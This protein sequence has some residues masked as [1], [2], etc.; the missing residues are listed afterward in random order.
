MARVLDKT[1]RAE[2]NRLLKS[3]GQA[4][5]KSF[6]D[7][8]IAQGGGAAGAGN[9]Q[10]GVMQ[11]KVSTMLNN[12]QKAAAAGKNKKAAQIGQKIQNQIQKNP[13]SA[14]PLAERYA[15]DEFNKNL[16]ANRPNQETIGGSRQYITNPDGSITAVDSLDQGQQAL[17][18]QDLAGRQTANEMFL[19]GLQGS[20][21][22]QAYDMSGLPQSPLSQDLASER[23]RIEGEVFDR[24]AGL[25]NR[26]ADRER[27][28]L[29]QQLY[30]RGNVP[31]TPAYDAAMRQFNEG[32]ESQLSQAR[33]NAVAVGGQE[34][35]RNFNIG[36]QGRQNALSE[37]V[38]GR[39]QPMSELQALQGF[40]GGPTM[41]P[42]FFGF[43]PIQYGGPQL[44]Q[45]LGFGLEAELGRGQLDVSRI[46]ANRSGGGGG[47]GYAGPSFS[48][49]GYP[50][51][52]LP[53]SVPRP[54][55]IAAGFASGLTQGAVAGIK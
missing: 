54:D 36:T 23:A 48:I 41:L 1:Q 38:F 45:Y 14:L 27:E 47:G 5:A 3:D 43:Q 50:D 19:S 8:V 18:D 33:Q 53:P 16:I 51:S 4:A 40:G 30:Q 17:Y 39:T 26:Q 46:A 31:G 21:F 9:R 24:D 44:G 55:P 11:N 22:G 49:G 29:E 10:G 25:I 15:Q 28:R 32:L 37:M 2:Y 13:L 7:S 6:R 12:Q 35:E 52:G 42:N 34:F 20:Q